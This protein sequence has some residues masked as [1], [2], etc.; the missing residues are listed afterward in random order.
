MTQWHSIKEKVPSNE[1]LILTD[2][3][4]YNCVIASSNLVQSWQAGHIKNVPPQF[5]PNMTVDMELI[6]YWKCL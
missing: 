4:F 3:L 1:F 5:F 6:A 2:E